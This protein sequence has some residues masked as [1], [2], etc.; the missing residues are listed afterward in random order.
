M[1]WHRTSFAIPVVLGTPLEGSVIV[2]LE[3]CHLPQLTQRQAHPLVLVPH[4][5]ILLS[6]FG[7]GYDNKGPYGSA[8]ESRPHVKLLLCFTGEP[9]IL[10]NITCTFIPLTPSRTRTC[11]QRHSLSLAWR[12]DREIRS[13]LILHETAF[14][15]WRFFT[16]YFISLDTFYLFLNWFSTHISDDQKYLC[17]SR[18]YACINTRKFKGLDSRE[19]TSLP[20]IEK[21]IYMARHFNHRRK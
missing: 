17:G 10:S 14:T 4:G 3:S 6:F 15:R 2:F 19:I 21:V 16:S 1:P 13:R 12:L 9:S 8:S 7:K 20:D 11:L 18:L 5:I